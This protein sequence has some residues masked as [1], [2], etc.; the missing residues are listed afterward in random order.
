MSALFP[1]WA[2]SVARASL[3][4]VLIVA[5]GI[6]IALMVWVRSS[7]ATGEHAV[8]PQPIRFDHRIHAHGLRI[9]CRFCHSSVELA[10]M[11]GV[12]PTTACVGCHTNALQASPTF[13]PVRASLASMRPIAWRRV[14]EL[15][16]FVFFDHSIHVAKGVGCETCHGRVDQMAQVFQATPMAMQWCV[17]CHRDPVPNLRPRDQITTMGWT[18]AHSPAVRDSIGRALMS[19]HGVQRLTSC[20]TCHR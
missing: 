14:N 6:P 4:A 13:A 10:P 19:A 8:V 2:N 5:V 16:D 20:T 1:W 15:P 17:G 7:F 18:D 9:D 12:P 11:A 3:L